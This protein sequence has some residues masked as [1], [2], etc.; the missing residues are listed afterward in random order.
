MFQY[1][2]FAPSILSLTPVIEHPNGIYIIRRGPAH[3]SARRNT[4]NPR[5]ILRKGNCLKR[6]DNKG[7]INKIQLRN[8]RRNPRKF[9]P[10]PIRAV[11]CKLNVWIM[12]QIHNGRVKRKEWLILSYLTL[13]NIF[14]EHWFWPGT[15]LEHISVWPNSKSI[16]LPKGA[17]IND[18]FTVLGLH[19][20]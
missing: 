5:M 17:L 6:D 18:F 1:S 4:N 14:N 15:N 7:I 9:D 16:Y 10:R 19:I 3:R 8:L 13:I 11:G 20:L 2:D 12:R